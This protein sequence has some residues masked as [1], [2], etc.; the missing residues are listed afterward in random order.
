MPRKTLRK[1]V[2]RNSKRKNTL[3]KNS[4]RNFRKNTKRKI[5][6]KNTKRNN[7]KLNIRGGAQ[8]EEL[9]RRYQQL[10]DMDREVPTK[11][12]FIIRRKLNR[13]VDH[14]MPFQV[15]NENIRDINSGLWGGPEGENTAEYF[16]IVYAY[17]LAEYSG[18]DRNT[19]GPNDH[20]FLD[21]HGNALKLKLRDSG[22]YNA[23][24]I[25]R[26]DYNNIQPEYYNLAY[27]FGEYESKYA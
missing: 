26:K 13:E 19:W 10:I 4:R 22:V 23:Y 15:K 18:F 1:N 27:Y 12:Y 9:C 3:R 8:D 17:I 24:V 20:K 11:T 14:S 21:Q 7:K 6:R 25:S 2:R 16:D 5:R